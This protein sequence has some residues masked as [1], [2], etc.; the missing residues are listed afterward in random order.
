MIFIWIHLYR[1]PQLITDSRAIIET[2]LVTKY[3][4]SVDDVQHS[5]QRQNHSRTVSIMW[6]DRSSVLSHRVVQG[7]VKVDTPTER[8]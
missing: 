2:D 4:V 7:I 3:A 5:T 6:S 1:M 8:K